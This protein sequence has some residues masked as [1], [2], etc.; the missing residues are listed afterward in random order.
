MQKKQ[1][2]V[3]V[4]IILCF[5]LGKPIEPG[6]PPPACRPILRSPFATRSKF[7]NV[8]QNSPG[9]SRC[10]PSNLS[11]TSFTVTFCQRFNLGFQ[12][13]SS[14]FTW[15]TSG[16]RIPELPLSDGP[17]VK[18]PVAVIAR[19]KHLPCSAWQKK[20]GMRENREV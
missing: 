18:L 8:L 1:L 11:K 15:F 7:S 14:I 9:C 16:N 6:S 12:N 19:R 2:S 20:Y 3:L 13:V 17:A 4:L 10:F 5:L